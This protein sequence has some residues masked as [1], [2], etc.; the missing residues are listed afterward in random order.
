MD[1]LSDIFTRRT[2]RSMAMVR[3]KCNKV[4]C[5]Y[6]WE[7]TG[8]RPDFAYITCP[9]CYNKNMKNTLIKNYENSHKMTEK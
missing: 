7:Y 4:E 3:L 6:E 8:N 2:N 9:V 1:T 5:G